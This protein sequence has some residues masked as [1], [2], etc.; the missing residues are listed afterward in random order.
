M[1]ALWLGHLVFNQRI[2]RFSVRVLLLKSDSPVDFFL[3]VDF[4]PTV[5][6]A[7][8]ARFVPS[9]PHFISIVSPR[10]RLLRP[11]HTSFFMRMQGGNSG[12]LRFGDSTGPAFA[13]LSAAAAVPCRVRVYGAAGS[14]MRLGAAAPGSRVLRRNTNL[15]SLAFWSA[16]SVSRSDKLHKRA[17]ASIEHVPQLCCVP[18]AVRSSQAAFARQHWQ[19]KLNHNT[20]R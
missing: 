10:R 14:A 4:I 20:A 16:L 3:C 11:R 13:R 15:L 19:P 1:Q 2:Q 17:L 12:Q 9:L 8:A 6:A 5:L 7:F 18:R